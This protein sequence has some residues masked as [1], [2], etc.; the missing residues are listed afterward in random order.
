M[1][2][3]IRT[4]V[5]ALVVGSLVV[6]ATA[7]AQD[8]EAAD[9]AWR[10]G[11]QAF[12]NGNPQQCIDQ[13]RVALREGG[14]AYDRWGWLH[15]TLGI[16]LG[17]RNQRDEAIS[18]LQ[19]GKDLV[20]EDS[21]RFMVNHALAQVYIGRG[22]TGDYDRA[23]AAEN[24]A[25]QYAGDA[26]QQA[27]VAK[28]LGQAYYFKEDWGNA[29]RQLS[30][31]AAARGNDVDVA[32]KLGRAYL[33]SGDANNAQEWFEKTLALDSDNNT[34]LTNL[35]RI[36]L[37]A[38]QW[39]GAIGYLERAIRNDPQNMQV[40]NMLGRAYL[41][42]RR[43]D[44]AIAQ[45]SQVTQAR[46]NDG[47]SQYNL[48]QAYQAAGDDGRAIQAYTAALANLPEGDLRAECLYDIGFVYEKVG[49]YEDALA[50]LEDSAAISAAAKTTEA[51]ERVRERIRRQ[52]EGGF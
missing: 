39:E 41:G 2:K 36:Q 14:E 52:K 34:A 22:N 5:A 33:E 28:T 51:I 31:A 46:P 23:I 18:E 40:R 3:I 48:G 16:C 49:R 30:Q 43:Y 15:M 35:G 42:T 29:V 27:L 7:F 17:Q 26:A 50:A 6:P 21:E 12:Q 32:Q 19:T 4:L 9:Q 13:M 47:P 37:N 44:D 25:S 24:E 20:T 1:N 8:A 11:Y 45:L 10:A 38:G